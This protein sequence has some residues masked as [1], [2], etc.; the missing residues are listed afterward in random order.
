MLLFGDM[1]LAVCG[2]GAELTVSAA[3]CETVL[4]KDAS[5]I[6]PEGDGGVDCEGPLASIIKSS[7]T[8][9]IQESSQITASRSNLT[10]STLI[11]ETKKA[12]ATAYLTAFLKSSIAATSRCCI[13]CTT[14]DVISTR[15]L[16]SGRNKSD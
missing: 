3:V 5:S 13:R 6:L 15:T 2:D 1:R 12:F 9:S 16:R 8:N 7:L 14:L 10:G 4:R 11:R